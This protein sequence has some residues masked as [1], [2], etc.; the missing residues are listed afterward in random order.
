MNQ[1]MHIHP[2]IHL[3]AETIKHR[4]D[5][6]MGDEYVSSEFVREKIFMAGR[7]R[8]NLFKKARGTILDVAVGS[9][10]NFAHYQ[11]LGSSYTGIELSPVMLARARMRALELGMAVNLREMDAEHLKFPDDSF[12]TVVSA[13]S[14]CTFPDPIAAL[15]EIQRVV[16]PNGRILLFEHGR[17]S[18]EF[19]GRWQDRITPQH[20]AMA[21]CRMNQEPQELVQAAGL[22]IISSKRAL[23]GI[24]HMLEISPSK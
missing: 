22:K 5:T 11:G 16:K 24:F 2:H 19:I 10:E 20:Y 21:G 1:H 13:M 17:S 9:G 4:Y 7:F 15:Q 23:F 8:R 18:W 6:Q 3:D 12:D 14:T